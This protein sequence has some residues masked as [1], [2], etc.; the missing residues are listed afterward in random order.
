M[1]FFS[2]VL[3]SWYSNNKRDLPWRD[4][5]D[6]YL[7]WLSEIILQQ[8]RVDQGLSYYTKFTATYPTII[9][10]AHASEEE[11]LRLW[12]GLGYYSRARN[13]HAAAN[14]VMNELNGVFPSTY[15]E[16][17]ELKGV[18]DYTASAIAS[19]A[20]DEVQPVLDGNVFRVIARYYGVEEDIANAK[21]AKVF[22]AILWNEIPSDGK[23]AH[24]FNQSIMEF[25]ALNCTPKKPHCVSCPLQSSCFAF[26]ERQQE[27]LPVKL[28]KTKVRDRF[29]YYLI[30]SKGNALWLKARGDKDIWGGLY[31]FPLLEKTER[32]E[33]VASVVSEALGD[34]FSGVLFYE[35]KLHKLS[36]QNIYAFF[37]K[38]DFD[39]TSYDNAKKYK[40]DEIL[41]LP[42]PVLIDNF[43]KAFYF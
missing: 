16:L 37:I 19:F 11:V 33:D 5:K 7:I 6:P 18:G 24:L 8:T 26:A 27:V 34:A 32:Q 28:K 3:I 31:D 10:L 12:Q 36:H 23:Q 38:V 40:L 15:R 14:Y 29:F 25:G 21:S 1:H 13:L 35:A 42:K 20:F 41:A 43:L 30:P 4:T 39:E 2:S 17:L 22:K 9:E